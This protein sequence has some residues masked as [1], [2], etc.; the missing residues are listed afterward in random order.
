VLSRAACALACLVAAG[1]VRPLVF[2]IRKGPEVRQDAVLWT[3]APIARAPHAWFD[4]HLRV[5]PPPPCAAV[6]W[7]WGDGRTVRD[8]DCAPDE[9][10]PTVYD[11]SH[12]YRI[13]GPYTVTASLTSRGQLVAR[14]STNVLVLPGLGQ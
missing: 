8:S 5:D 10:G 4:F 1:C 6:E 9:V 2:P 12:V 3:F 13:P 7:E 14:A 11:M